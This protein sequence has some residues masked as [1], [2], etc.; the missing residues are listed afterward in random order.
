MADDVM[1]PVA[2]VAGSVVGQVG[3][4]MVGIDPIDIAEGAPVATVTADGWIEAMDADQCQRAAELFAEA[5]RRLRQGV[6]NG[7]TPTA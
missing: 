1:Q 7:S 6:L 2:G 4:L 3:G 5:A